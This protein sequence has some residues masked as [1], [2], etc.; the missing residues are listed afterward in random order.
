MADVSKG[1]FPSVKG[2]ED[3]K[4]DTSGEVTETALVEVKIAD[5]DGGNPPG[6]NDES[7]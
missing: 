5:A 4:G 7:I 6:G 3:C 2:V 1:L